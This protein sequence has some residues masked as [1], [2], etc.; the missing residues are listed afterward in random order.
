MGTIRENG[1]KVG[2]VA[3]CRECGNLREVR[4]RIGFKWRGLAERGNNL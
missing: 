1:G 3:L 2:K 4:S